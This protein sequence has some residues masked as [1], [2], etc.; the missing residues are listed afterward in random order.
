VD[1]RD[2]KTGIFDLK[3]RKKRLGGASKEEINAL[4]RKKF[5]YHDVD[6]ELREA[7]LIQCF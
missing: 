4:T 2:G 1:F 5:A 7:T 6:L 3:I